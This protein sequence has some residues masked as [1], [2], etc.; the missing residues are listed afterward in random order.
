RRL[1]RIQHPDVNGGSQIAAGNFTLIVEAYRILSDPVERM[2][3]DR[4]HVPIRK[5]S[6]FNSSN[7]YAT[8]M[9]RAAVQARWDRAVDFVLEAERRENMARTQAVFT[10]VTLFMSTFI[11]VMLKPR[12]WQNFDSLGRTVLFSLFAVG[13]VHLFFRIRVYLRRYTY[14]RKPVPVSEIK[15]EEQLLKPY[16]RRA[17]YTFLVAGYTISVAAGLFA[18]EYLTYFFVDMSSIFDHNLRY[19]LFFYPPIAVLIIDTMHSIATRIDRK[20]QD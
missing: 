7:L 8:R 19:D 4:M 17:A 10:T 15:D 9:R 14:D 12:F 2:N 6:V 3:F 5:N 18:G 1:A 16:S 20:I 11:V 13:M